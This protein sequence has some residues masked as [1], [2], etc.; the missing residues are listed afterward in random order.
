M[1]DSNYFEAIFRQKKS[2]DKNGACYPEKRFLRCRI[3]KTK[4]E[5]GL[6]ARLN[7]SKT[8]LLFYL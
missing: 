5:L 8:T 3:I 6:P 1:T 7:I 4:A 2:C